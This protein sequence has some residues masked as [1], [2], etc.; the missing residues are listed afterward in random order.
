M[1]TKATKI[2]F[3]RFM[4][5]AAAA[6]MI[7][8]STSPA[9]AD[10]PPKWWQDL[11]ED[12]KE[13]GKEKLEEGTEE[14]KDQTVDVIDEQTGGGASFLMFVFTDGYKVWQ[15]SS[16]T[17]FFMALSLLFLFFLL[18]F[19]KVGEENVGLG[20]LVLPMLVVFWVPAVLTFEYT[21]RFPSWTAFRTSAN[22]VLGGL[23]VL[24]A[25]IRWRTWRDMGDA[26]WGGSKLYFL[27][28]FTHNLVSAE[29]LIR[30]R[31][32]DTTEP[33]TVTRTLES[34]DVPDGESP[35]TPDAEP[36]RTP[37]PPE[38][39]PEPAPTP[40][41]AY[42]PP[43]PNCGIPLSFTAK[44]HCTRCGHRL[45][46]PRQAGHPT[47]RKKSKFGHDPDMFG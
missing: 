3:I 39:A 23:C 42:G 40:A 2:M 28:W 30:D 35:E 14:A 17:H 9:Q 6:I 8:G 26:F 5:M 27:G 32:L 25:A 31:G 4:V 33:T 36:V 13:W 22:P 37:V 29:Q 19:R 20:C 34:F 21:E 1:M 45:A 43:C 24:A 11:K 41:P 38:P 16:G 46:A 12:G 7:L 15:Y 44:E 47:T 10:W 18:Y